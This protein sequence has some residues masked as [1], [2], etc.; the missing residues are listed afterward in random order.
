MTRHAAALHPGPCQHQA[1]RLDT[2]AERG[3]QAVGPR[4]QNQ[5]RATRTV[6]ENH[7]MLGIRW[8]LVGVSLTLSIALIAR[9]DVL[10]GGLLGVLAVVRMVMFVR[11]PQRRDEFRRRGGQRGMARWTLTRAPTLPLD[12][13]DF[14]SWIV[15]MRAAPAASAI[16]T[17]RATDARRAAG[18]R[19][20]CTSARR[21]R[22]ARS[23]PAALLFP[24]P[25]CRRAT[26]SGLRR[27]WAL[28]DA[29]RRPVLDLRAPTRARVAPTTA[30]CSPAAGVEVEA[31]TRR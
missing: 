30:G 18:R 31:A 11:I 27:A 9:G 23:H 26:C 25:A 21:D 22:D 6:R 7:L 1:R 28:P 5:V 16:R 12:A 20:S 4:A 14:G 15:E 3:T 10:I 24:A 8:V 13:G 29:R 17:C 2:Q 19:S